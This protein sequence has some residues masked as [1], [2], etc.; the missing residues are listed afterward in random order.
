MASKSNS[1]PFPKRIRRT[2]RRHRRAILGWL[3][4]LAASPSLVA[5]YFVSLPSKN[6]TDGSVPA[7]QQKKS[8]NKLHKNNNNNNAD[9]SA[10]T[11]AITGSAGLRAASDQTADAAST[12]FQCHN[13]DTAVCCIAWNAGIDTDNWW[14]HRPDYTTVDNSTH[15]CFHR[16]QHPARAAFLQQ[17]HNRQWRDD[18]SSSSVSKKKCVQ[19]TQIS[20]GYAA[21]LMAVARSF[22]ATHKDGLVFQISR[23]HANAVWNFCP[24][25]NSSH[26]WAYCATKDLNCYFLPLS[27]CPPVLGQNDAARGTKPAAGP[28]ADEFYWLR[29]Y[30]FRQ[31]HKLRR[32]LQEFIAEH[33]VPTVEELESCVALHVRRGDIAF[34]RGRRYAAVHEYLE[35]GKVPKGTTIVLLTDDASTLDEV[36]QYHRT[37]YHW[38]VLDRP[39]YRGSQ[40]GF[41]EFV[42][43]NDPS[44]EIL[45]ILAEAQMASACRLLVHGKSGFVAIISDA[46]KAT[47]RPF[48]T[49][50]L[51]T[52]QDKKGQAKMDPKDRAETY[53]QDIQ[54]KL[55]G[56]TSS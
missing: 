33:H 8:R 26:H 1:L 53:L 18:H 41:E 31:R 36:D 12:E 16:M 54:K 39:R 30:T 2:L 38:V 11:L 14:L 48:Q 56:E 29:Q 9:A 15:T 52:Q 3:L 28:A 20:S 19:R 37:D 50:Y 34:G 51:D 7:Q 5:F 13:D 49:V 21:A 25:D 17:L 45:A 40:G 47:G 23:G 27:N 22:Y 55:G 24:R 44:L 32:K 4:L 10:R 35:A 42:P 6:R 46:M 43:S